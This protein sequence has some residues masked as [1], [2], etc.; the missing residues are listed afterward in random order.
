MA[1][2][3][4]EYHNCLAKILA[5]HQIE[6]MDKQGKTKIVTAQNILLAMGGRPF[7]PDIPGVKEYAITSDDI[8][9]RQTAPGRTLVFGSG[10]IGTE[11]SGF[12]KG[13]GYPTELLFRNKILSEF[14][15]DMALR[16]RRSLEEIGVKT[17]KGNIL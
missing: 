2:S 17:T 10:Y 16:V 12:I 9:W 13:L 1:K 3:E 8:F 4:V 11:C 5:P 6:L 7:L 15:Q 14:D